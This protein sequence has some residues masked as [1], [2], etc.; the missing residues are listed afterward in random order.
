MSTDASAHGG[1]SRP[2]PSPKAPPDSRV[3]ERPP[4]TF[5]PLPRCRAQERGAGKVRATSSQ[6]LAQPTV[7]PEAVAIGTKGLR[8]PVAPLQQLGDLA[9][10]GRRLAEGQ[11]GV[12]EAFEEALEGLNAVV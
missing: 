3:V 9:A 10:E 7:P 2:Y 5:A 6:G 1:P 12:A 8:L 11:A 4:H